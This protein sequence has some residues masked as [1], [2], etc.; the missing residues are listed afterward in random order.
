[1]WGG[2]SIY[3]VCN[4]DMNG[5]EPKVENLEK[6]VDYDLAFARYMER[7]KLADKSS[8]LVNS[9]LWLVYIEEDT[10][11]IVQF[12]QLDWKCHCKLVDLDKEGVEV[13]C[14]L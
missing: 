13:K 2:K 10:N 14:L 12:E 11:R 4:Y 8:C 3:G 6:F 5:Y 7:L 1:M 9:D